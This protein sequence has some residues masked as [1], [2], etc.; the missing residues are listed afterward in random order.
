LFCWRKVLEIVLSSQLSPVFFERDGFI[1][2]SLTDEKTKKK[3]VQKV[4]MEI[5]R[6]VEGREIRGAETRI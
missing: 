1:L 6:R 3:Q 4:A 2:S 5:A